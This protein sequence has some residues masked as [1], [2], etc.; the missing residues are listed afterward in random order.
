VK[1]KAINYQLPYITNN[2]FLQINIKDVFTERQLWCPVPSWRIKL[3][4]KQGRKA[5]GFLSREQWMYISDLSSIG[6][7]TFSCE[8][9]HTNKTTAS[10]EY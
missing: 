7:T 9:E 1:G 6:F 8:T 10:T 4:W 5:L 2:V 3:P